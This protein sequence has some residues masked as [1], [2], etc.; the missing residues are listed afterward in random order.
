M[1]KN[2]NSVALS[3]DLNV[4]TL[5]IKVYKHLVDQGIFE[6]GRS[7]KHVKENDLVHDEWINCL[8]S[9]DI[10]EQKLSFLSKLLLN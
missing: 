1:I 4:I 3:N 8:K 6:I 10:I 9:I 7:L 2:N 5:E